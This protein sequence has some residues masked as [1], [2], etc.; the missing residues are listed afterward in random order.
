MQGGIV[1]AIRV[2]EGQRIS[3]SRLKPKGDVS[4]KACSPSSEGGWALHA[5]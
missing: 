3:N 4:G 5:Q 1:K 2:P